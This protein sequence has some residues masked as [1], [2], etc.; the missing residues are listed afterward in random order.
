MNRQDGP[1]FVQEQSEKMDIARDVIDVALVKGGFHHVVDTPEEAAAHKAG[2]KK[3][4]RNLS[5]HVCPDRGKDALNTH[6]PRL[7]APLKMRHRHESE[8][9]TP[10]RLR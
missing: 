1:V 2:H 6:L 5:R 3:A 10:D 8:C 9:L 7:C 4:A